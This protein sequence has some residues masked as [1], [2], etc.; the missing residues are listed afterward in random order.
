[1][2]NTA[3]QQNRGFKR[4]Y[5]TI[6]FL[7]I[8]KDF[9]I[10]LNRNYVPMVKKARVRHVEQ[11][12]DKDD[13]IFILLENIRIHIKLLKYIFSHLVRNNYVVDDHIK[14]LLPISQENKRAYKNFY[15]PVKHPKKVP[16]YPLQQ[17]NK[18][19]RARRT[20]NQQEV[21]SLLRKSLA[22][23]RMIS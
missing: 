2:A 7:G 15:F 1:M 19:K 8:K 9:L 4:F 10:I 14:R 12:I 5:S 20:Q 22:S 18:T 11:N 3:N 13:K 21:N 23:S 17:M 16:Y 6:I